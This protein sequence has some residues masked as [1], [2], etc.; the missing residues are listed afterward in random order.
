M[1]NQHHIDGLQEDTKMLP[2]VGYSLEPS[3]I[4]PLPYFPNIVRQVRGPTNAMVLTYLEMIH[5]C[6]QDANGAIL[7]RPVTVD[8][9]QACQ[10]IQISRRT[11]HVALRCLGAWFLTED[12]RQRAE[13]VARA[14]IN[15]NHSLHG[16]VKFYSI[17]GPKEFFAAGIRLSI[18]RNQPHLQTL[19]RRA[20]LICLSTPIVSEP[21]VGLHDWQ[22]ASICA[23]SRSLPSL[24]AEVMPAWGDRRAERWD[25]WRRANGKKSANPGRM[26]DAKKSVRSL[27]DDVGYYDI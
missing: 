9:D 10:D 23:S 11:L 4:D 3:T 18:K 19:F 27:D 22:D 25:R 2:R 15:E 6:P 20:G 14:F 17:V 21:S 16:T 24:L 8:C 13:R 7:D 1:D 5:P 26:R 12:Q